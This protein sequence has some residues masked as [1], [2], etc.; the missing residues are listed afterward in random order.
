MYYY[1]QKVG[2]NEDWTPIQAHLPLET[3][4]PTFVTI[5]AVDTLINKDTPNEVKTKV[6]HQGP[7]Y[8]DFDDKEEVANSI[9]DVKAFVKKL[10]A[11]ELTASD[12][13]IFLSGKKGLHV[14]VPEVC[15]VQK[16]VPVQ[17][18]VAIYKEIA[19]SLAV[20]TMDF[21]VYTAGRGRQF[22]TCYNVRE[23]GN[24]KVPITLEELE[25]LTVEKYNEYCAAPRVVTGHA[26]QWRGK[27]ALLYDQAFQKISKLKPKVRKP[28]SPEV[29]AQQLPVFQKLA[30]GELATDAGFNNIA[31]QLALYA[32]EM[33]WTEDTFISMCDGVINKHVSD[34]SRYNTPAR[35]ERELRRMFYYLEDNPSFEYSVGGIKACLVKVVDAPW[36]GESEPAE[37]E[38]PADAPDF[39]GIYAGTTAYMAS[40]GEDGDVPVSNF[41]FRDI[42]VLRSIETGAIVSIEASMVNHR[43]QYHPISLTPINFTGG[44]ALQNAV[45]AH[46]GSFSGT[47]IHARGVYQAMLREVSEDSYVLESEGV[48]L[49]HIGKGSEPKKEYIVWA[50]RE[51]VKSS[52]NLKKEGFSVTFQGFPDPRGLIRTD[53]LAAPTLTELLNSEDGAQRFTSCME[54]LI[55]SHSPE[56]MGKMLGWA[57]ACFFAPLFQKRHKKF[58]LLH[59]YGP[60]GNGKTETTRGVLNMFYH[61]EN[62]AETTPNSSVFAI[63][64]LVGASASIPIFLD[65]YKP[66]TIAKEKLDL[67]RSMLRDMYN[68]KEV[69]RGGGNRNTSQNFNAL[70]TLKLQAPMVFVAEA[71][72]TETAIVE[73]SIMVSFR[74]LAGRQQVKAYNSALTFYK[75]QEPL[76][77]LGLEIANRVIVTN[78]AQTSL[79]D[80]DKLLVW[81]SDKFLPAADDAEKVASG[82]MTPEEYR[83]RGIMRPRT[84]FNNT[85]A[86]F[87]LRVIKSIMEEK[88]GKEV[89]KEIFADAFS[90]M[91][92]GAYLGMDALTAATLPEFV[93]VLSVFSDMSKM[94]A[95]DPYALVEGQEYNL[96]EF[97]GQ[98][99][100]VLATGQAYRKYRAYMKN[101]NSVPLYPS[102]ESF[103]IALREIPQF[104]RFA[105]GTARLSVRTMVFSVDELLRA[106]VPLWKGKGV[107]LPL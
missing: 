88:L 53:L 7:M 13:Q 98:Q 104:L 68:A 67:V 11:H 91:V 27:F 50:D 32:R 79:D 106:G 41:V 17:G 38:K 70:S 100:L 15:F 5:L 80:F 74:R 48:N 59:V 83:L 54:S 21:R 94:D 19:F 45:A 66:H 93:K 26:P 92:K 96:S 30:G 23:N 69:Q 61:R 63:Q 6:K 65:E 9:T 95:Q 14:I 62:I 8:F 102:E 20:D 85:V 43:R 10:Q 78:D 89:F 4:K 34:G 86:V 87:G 40:K 39:A 35:R 75:D 55:H 58:P 2:G 105:E 25:T 16:S 36:D 37:G 101:S 51:G 99:V 24:Y 57:A 71:P 60:A 84:V 76:A 90:A 73:R 31:M 81:A 46:G 82:D 107:N 64:Q 1:Y 49:F 33:G 52:T 29:L 18:L 56:V 44:S 77:S 47:D 103:G 97:A 28:T 22:R 42:R 3:I 12:F 72:E